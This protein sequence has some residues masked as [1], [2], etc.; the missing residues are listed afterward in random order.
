MGVDEAEFYD[1][2]RIAVVPMGF[3]FPGL[4]AAGA[5]LPPRPECAPLWRLQVFAAL[6][7]VRLILLIGR[8]AQAWHLGDHD[9]GSLDDA[10]AAWPETLA[11]KPALLALPHPSWRNN[12][13]L[14]RNSW[15][16]RDVIPVL[17]Q[18]VRACLRADHARRDA[19]AAISPAMAEKS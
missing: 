13:W 14:K 7:E 10:V 11:R 16:E 4:D 1:E 18:Q 9:P 2:T 8:Y 12:A 17:Q 5:D 15:F 19:A 3:C 6:P